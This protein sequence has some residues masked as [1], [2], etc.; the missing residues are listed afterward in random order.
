MKSQTRIVTHAEEPIDTRLKEYLEALRLVPERDAEAAAQGKV[1]FL[2]ELEDILGSVQAG[3]SAAPKDA[4]SAA[5]YTGMRTFESLRNA[6]QARRPWAAYSLVI[7]IVIVLLFG[8]VG[9][10]ARAAETAIPGDALYPIKTGLEQVQ[11]ALSGDLDHQAG[12]YLNFAAHRL[13]EIET[14]VDQGRYQKALKLAAK[15]QLNI[16]KAQQIT[17]SLVKVN[18]SRAVQRQKEMDLQLARFSEQLSEM[19]SRIPP[20][21]QP[22]FHAVEPSPRQVFPGVQPALTSTPVPGAI[23]TPTPIDKPEK[24]PGGQNDGQD[25]ETENG[26]D[27]ESGSGNG[28][29]AEEP[30][31]EGSEGESQSGRPETAWRWIMEENS[32]N[33]TGILTS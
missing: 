16:D 14:L 29:D 25:G 15:F 3:K 7:M 12:L 22:G 17:D 24:Q 8:W 30:A 18:P 6:W 20:A 26:T 28:F 4:Q 1:K 10:T 21:Y 11:I 31:T 23:N 27:G 2:A 5:P 19:I 33:I 32:H 9:V 13:Q